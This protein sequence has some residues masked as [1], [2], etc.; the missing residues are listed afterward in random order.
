MRLSPVFFF[1]KV[2]TRVNKLAVNVLFSVNMLGQKMSD[3]VGALQV[4]L[5]L[6]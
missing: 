3:S 2:A 5:S 6:C 1:A 4:P